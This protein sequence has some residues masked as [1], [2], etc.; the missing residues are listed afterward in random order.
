MNELVS[1]LPTLTSMINERQHKQSDVIVSSLP[2]N[3]TSVLQQIPAV[4][5]ATN[6][7]TLTSPNPKRSVVRQLEHQLNARNMLNTSTNNV[8]LPVSVP[9]TNSFVSNS[10]NNVN[11]P[12]Q[13]SP[14]NTYNIDNNINGSQVPITNIQR[15]SSNPVPLLYDPTID[16][17][18]QVAAYNAY[19]SDQSKPVAADVLAA[20]GGS[21][22]N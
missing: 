5:T 18:E 8:P 7:M 22:T 19:L 15:Y 12:I 10:R 2:S 20:A 11:V 16:P 13:L 21:L 4:N 1:L 14:A 17:E 6:E 3:L 9:V